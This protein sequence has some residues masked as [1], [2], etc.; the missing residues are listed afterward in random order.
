MN[1][2]VVLRLLNH[3]LLFMKRDLCIIGTSETADRVTQFCERYDWFNI[4]GYAVD[5][6]LVDDNNKITKEL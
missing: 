1:F 5:N 2:G 6:N 4:V 3:L